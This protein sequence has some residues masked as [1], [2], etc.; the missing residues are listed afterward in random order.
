MNVSVPVDKLIYPGK[1]SWYTLI[2]SPAHLSA[3]VD[4]EMSQS[5]RHTNAHGHSLF[6]LLRRLYVP[7]RKL[8]LLATV[9]TRIFPYPAQSG[10]LEARF[11]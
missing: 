6:R 4:L 8:V 1:A 11:A 9:D 7:R 5:Y 3:Q 10:L 2:G